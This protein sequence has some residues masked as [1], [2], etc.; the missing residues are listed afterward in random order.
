MDFRRLINILTASV[1]LLSLSACS[2]V[3]DNDDYD[4]P[5]NT[6]DSY[7]NL[8]IAVSN[9]NSRGT[10]AV[11]AGGEDG[12]GREAGFER[13]NAVTGITLILYKGAGINGDGSQKLDLVRYFPVTRD[14]APATQGTEYTAGTGDGS[15]PAQIEAK[16]TTGPQLIGKYGVSKLDFTSEYHALV[17]ANYDLTA[18]LTEGTSTLADVREQVLAKVY[19]GDAKSPASSAVNFIMS[20][21][22]D[23][24]LQFSATDVKKED[25]ASG[26]VTYDFDGQPLIIERMA[27]RIDFWAANS[28]GYKDTYT[29]PGYEYNVTGGSD[30]FVIT[31]IMPFNL[32]NGSTIFGNEYIFKRIAE[33][34]AKLADAS[35][36]VNYLAP[37]TVNSYVVDP[38]TYDKTGN[39]LLE[40][41]LGNTTGVYQMIA[42]NTLE[43][44]PYYHSIASMHGVSLAS[45]TISG[46]ENVIVC[47]PMENTLLPA[48]KLYY[49]ATGVIV[50]GDY[51]VGGTGTPTTYY[52]LS[53]L[54]H[55]GDKDTYDVQPHTS[56][57]LSVTQD[58][59]TTPMNYGVVRNN[60]YRISINSIDSKGTLELKIKVKEWDPYVHEFIYM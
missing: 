7:I 4:E 33:D 19:S 29:T 45:S 9:G 20:S 5:R 16:Y 51:Y 39:H 21:E 13:E 28:N 40:N 53:Y 56:S 46:Q 50:V 23:N 60:I 32:T 6:G 22:E 48:S 1:C 54:R 8:T 11:P 52:Y 12:D 3:T 27:A 38:K 49:Y 25:A 18:G 15:H 31:G 43:T 55:Q 44:S 41:P 36:P 35:K 10:R 58:M 59:G 47:Y 26:D 14:G 57:T 37:E 42:D 34:A 30:K 17:I 24:K 2:L